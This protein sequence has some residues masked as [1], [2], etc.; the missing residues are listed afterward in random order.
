MRPQRWEPRASVGAR[1]LSREALLP[2]STLRNGCPHKTSSLPENTTDCEH[3]DALQLSSL[4][5]T[6]L[7]REL[8]GAL[9]KVT[10]PRKALRE[11]EH[12]KTHGSQLG[13]LGA[14]GAGQPPRQGQRG[15]VADT[16]AVWASPW[17]ATISKGRARWEKIFPNKANDKA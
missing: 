1:G 10:G 11:D 17:G 15:R 4:E 13:W 16:R 5:G 9:Q 8:R 14:R 12:V 2:H 6:R 7:N 3:R